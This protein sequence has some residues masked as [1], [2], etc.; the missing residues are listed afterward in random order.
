MS[1]A[2]DISQD[3]VSAIIEMAWDDQT[4]FDSIEAQTG[5]TEKQVIKIMRKQL[6]A[7]SFQVWRARVTGRRSKHE[8]LSVGANSDSTPKS[9]AP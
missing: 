4:S 8:K 1:E 9:R 3:E 7:R 6:K 5:L 2:N